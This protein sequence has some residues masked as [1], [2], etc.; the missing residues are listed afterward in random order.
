M[1][2]F[3]KLYIFVYVSHSPLTLIIAAERSQD[4][5]G[6]GHLDLFSMTALVGD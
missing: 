4:F 5:Q 1:H 3:L 2:L 6:A